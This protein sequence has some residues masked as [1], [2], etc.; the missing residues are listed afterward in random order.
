MTPGAVRGRGT[1]VRNER[2]R[3]SSS[4]PRDASQATDSGIMK[5]ASGSKVTSGSA[6]IQ[7]MPRHPMSCSSRMATSAARRLPSGMPP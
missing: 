2:A 3:A 1:P 6:P 4:R 5:Y 7:N